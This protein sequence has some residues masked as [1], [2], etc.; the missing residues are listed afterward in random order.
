[1]CTYVTGPLC[2][3]VHTPGGVCAPNPCPPPGAC[4]DPQGVCSVLTQSACGAQGGVFIAGGSCQSLGVCFGACCDVAAGS[5]VFTSFGQCAPSGTQVFMGPGT[6]C[7]AGNPCATIGA[8][9]NLLSF[10]CTLTDAAG[11]IIGAPTQYFGPGTVCNPSPCAPVE[12]CCDYCTRSCQVVPA[13]GCPP[14]LG[15]L[16]PGS[17]CAPDPCR[18]NCCTPSAPTLCQPTDAPRCAAAGG[19]WWPMFGDCPTS[20]QHIFTFLADYFSGILRVDCD[21]NC[22]IT[23]NDIFCFLMQ[24]FSG[25]GYDL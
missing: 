10:T 2:A 20:P 23:V 11:C 4:C 24:Y 21:N 25:C 18:A 3:G 8:C 13:G 7:G 14:T 17:T 1:M 16:V 19:N 5:C 22:Q 9:C 15:F 12:V 6:G